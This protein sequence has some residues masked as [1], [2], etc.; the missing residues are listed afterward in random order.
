MKSGFS[1]YPSCSSYASRRRAAPT[2]MQL[3]VFRFSGSAPDDVTGVLRLTAAWPAPR[4]AY[5]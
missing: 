4:A 2:V 3:S 5:H 1:L